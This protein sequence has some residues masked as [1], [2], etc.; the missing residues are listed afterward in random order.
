MT[1]PALDL[2][3]LAARLKK[4][5]KQNRRL[6]FFCLLMLILWIF[7]GFWGETISA[8]ILP[9]P[10]AAGLPGAAPGGKSLQDLINQ[11]D[12]VKTFKKVED[13]LNRPK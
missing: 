6:K 10:Q 5:E 11:A 1:E 13:A 4:V 12:I 3:T 8:R 9:G 7:G 2:K